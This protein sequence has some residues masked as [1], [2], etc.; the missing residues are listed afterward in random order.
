MASFP[1]CKSAPPQGRDKGKGKDR[2]KHLSLDASPEKHDQL[3]WRKNIPT[4]ITL[5]ATTR[6][7][8]KWQLISWPDKWKNS[9]LHTLPTDYSSI[10][11][12]NGQRSFLVSVVSDKSK[13]LVPL[14]SNLLN[15]PSPQCMELA[16]EFSLCYLL[17]SNHM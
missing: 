12:L 5:W 17:P 16:M 3:L 9:H 1:W 6:P 13:T 11:H 8:K 4:D 10:S 14:N 15:Y 2:C 7:N